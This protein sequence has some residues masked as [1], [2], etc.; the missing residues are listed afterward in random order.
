MRGNGYG[1]GAAVGD[2]DNDGRTDLYVTAYGGNIL[3]RNRG[4]GTFEDVTAKAGVAAG[5]W[6]SS[7]AWVDYDQRRPA[8]P[9]RRAL[10]EVGLRARHLVR[11]P[12]VKGI[13]RTA[14]PTSSSRSTHIV[15][16]NRGDGTFEDATAKA[17]WS[18]SRG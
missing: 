18:E 12:A 14:I 6:S 3:Y 7:A 17:G 4:D 5:G 9:D 10:P 15:Y 2:Y 13:A 1:M 8:R 11:Q 16:R